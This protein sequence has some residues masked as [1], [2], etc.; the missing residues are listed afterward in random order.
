M[1]KNEVSVETLMT[2]GKAK[3]YIHISF[4]EF[5]QYV[6]CGHRHLIL[7]YLALDREPPSI[8]L[9]FGDAM[10]ASIEKTIKESIGTSERIEFF[11]ERFTSNMINNMQGF[12]GFE[13]MKLFTEQGCHLLSTIDFVKLNNDYEI[14]S[15]EEPLY[16]VVHGIYRF[17]GFIDLVLKNRSTKRYV[18]LD[19]KTSTQP[20]IM[21]YKNKDK[22]FLMQMKLYKFFWAKKHNVNLANI[23]TKYMVLCRYMNSKKPEMGY[24]D[25]VDVPMS[26]SLGEIKGAVELMAQTLRK[27]HILKTFKKAK[28]IIDDGGKPVV[29]SSGNFEF[30]E[31]PCKFCQYRGG[32]HPLC[33]SNFDQDVSLLREHKRI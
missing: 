29:D 26:S 11:K 2:E 28:F 7:K 19:W 20:W 18:I 33:N 6:K 17:K 23:D 3:G 12:P 16:E 15:V 5:D 8:H 1:I 25:V 32:K 13:D 21:Q 22:V 27:I 31:S 4:S 14:I 10:H 30:D 24:G 9:Y